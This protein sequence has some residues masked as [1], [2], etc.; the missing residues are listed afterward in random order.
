MIRRRKHDDPAAA[1]ASTDATGGRQRRTGI[2]VATRRPH[3]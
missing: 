3:R 1:P 2:G